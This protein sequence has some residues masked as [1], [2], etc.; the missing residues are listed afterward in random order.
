MKVRITDMRDVDI[1]RYRF[2]FDLTF[3]ALFLN[4]KGRVLGRYG[5]R[6]V[7]GAERRISQTGLEN[8]MARALEV[9]QEEKSDPPRSRPRRRVTPHTHPGAS[10]LWKGQQRP[11]CYHCHMVYDIERQAARDARRWR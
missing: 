11:E 10:S 9:Y 3:S 7:R 8:A 5:T 4:S 2:D 1:S 6:D